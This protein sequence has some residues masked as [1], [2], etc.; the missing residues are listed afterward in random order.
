[1][2]WNLLALPLASRA[3]IYCFTDLHPAGSADSQAYGVSG[4]QQ[5]G[6]GDSGA[7]LWSGTARSAVELGGSTCFGTSGSQQIGYAYIS[8]PGTSH[9]LLWSSTA[10]SVVDMNP[11]GFRYSECFAISGIQQVGYAYPNHGPDAHAI[12]WSGTPGSAVDLTPTGFTFAVASGI[13]R[14]QVVGEGWGPATGDG[15]HAILWPGASAS[16]VID[17]HPSGFVQ[18]EATGISGSQQVGFGF[19]R[20]SN[21][22]IFVHALVWSGTASSVVDLNPRGI[23]D[24]YAS[25]TSGNQ[26][27]GDGS[28]P[29]TGDNSHA[30]L[31]SGTADSVVDLHS[32]LASDYSA[33]SANGIDT[34]GNIVGLAYLP[35]G[36]THAILWM[37]LPESFV[38]CN[39]PGQRDAVAT[40]TTGASVTCSPPSGS[41]LPIGMTTV[42]CTSTNPS[43]TYNFTVTVR[44]CEPPKIQSVTAEPPSLWPPNHRV[45][46]VTL[47]V[48][49][50]DNCHVA[51][52]KIISVS[53]SEG[54][55][56]DWQITGDL[57]VNLRAERAGNAARVYSITV[58]CLDDSGNKATAIAQVLVEK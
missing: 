50:T 25:G 48:S 19:G 3:A 45:Q 20:L 40:Y 11:S 12:L 5:V 43:F 9:A 38:L 23:T 49:A 29:A 57:T 51:R 10:N 1:M 4:N 13:S 47:R 37:P 24:S 41:V 14:S 58:E 42:T 16:N 36:H 26:Q 53:A 35:S 22:N 6:W 44:D 34:N 8:P 55:S 28:G 54:S 33:S 17:L 56:A 30:L 2:A 39:D 21:G 52:S 46:P 18:S 7:L 32:F 15:V 27:V 31:W